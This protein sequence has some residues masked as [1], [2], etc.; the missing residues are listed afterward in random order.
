M[1]LTSKIKNVA[2]VYEDAEVLLDE[3]SCQTQKE[4]ALT[5]GVLNNFISF[6]IIGNDSKAR[7]LGSI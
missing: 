1:N 4:L 7:E 6:E 2:E 5:L 3:D